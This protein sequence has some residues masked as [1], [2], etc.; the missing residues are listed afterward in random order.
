MEKTAAALSQQLIYYRLV[1]LWVVCEAF[2]G[3]IIHGLKIPVSGLVVGSS[4][5]ICI[6]LIA[7]HVPKKGAL[8]KATIVV[9]VFKMMLSPQ[10]P[11]PAYFAVFF[12]GAIA[13]ILFFRR[14]NYKLS[15][16]VFAII[17]LFE[18]A[19]QRI[20]VLTILY[21]EELWKAI[22]DFINGFTGKGVN[23]SYLLISIYLAIHLVVGL[24]VG[25]FSAKLPRKI[26]EWKTNGL[27]VE[28]M[29]PK[30]KQ[31]SPR[32]K[33]FS[34]F[35]LV[36]ILILLLLLAW[37]FAFPWNNFVAVNRVIQMLI[38]SCIILICWLLV[39]QP[40]LALALKKWLM[41]EKRRSHQ[42]VTGILDLLP[43]TKTIVEK[44]W[45]FSSS[46]KGFRRLGLFCRLVLTNT[47][48]H[49]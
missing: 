27:P 18:S 1:A 38:R 17:A 23:Y 31:P 12:Q 16:Y 24:L 34:P 25:I 3:G 44:S 30:T 45:Q 21:G 19:V 15:C 5:V 35:L 6:C 33:R 4:A 37:S 32:K 43:T 8:I 10:S 9:A 42:V 41:K 46:Q 28:P 40:L 39:L 29:E 26:I 48:R 11:L 7:W 2:L 22:N 14:I 49:A 47:L 36:S 13:E 20:F